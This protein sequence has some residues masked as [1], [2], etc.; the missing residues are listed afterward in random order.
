[1]AQTLWERWT[2][3]VSLFVFKKGVLR[4]IQMSLEFIQ[5]QRDD[6]PPRLI[7]W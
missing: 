5:R 4:V 3:Q 2:P 7:E 1:M 6:Q